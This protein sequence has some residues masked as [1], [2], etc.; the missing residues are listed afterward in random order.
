MLRLYDT[1]EKAIAPKTQIRLYSDTQVQQFD[2]QE[3]K[4]K[5]ELIRQQAEQATAEA[6]RAGSFGGIIKETFKPKNL[7]EAAK[8]VAGGIYNVGKGIVEQYTKPSETIKQTEEMLGYGTTGNKVEDIITTPI[9]TVGK[10]FVRTFG[11]M[12]EP[13]GKDIAEIIF[14][15]EIMP[16]VE[17]GEMPVEV[18]DQLD[19][20]KKSNLQIVGDVSLA[21]LSAYSPTLFTKLT[22]GKVVG[23]QV[24]KNIFQKELV[25]GITGKIAGKGIAS[26]ML[27]GAVQTIPLGTAFGGAQVLASGS[28]DPGE[29]TKIM[30]TN[31]G[32]MGILGA[33]ISGAVPVTKSIL[34]KTIE[35]KAKIQKSLIEKGYPPKEAEIIANH[36]GSETATQK[37]KVVDAKEIIEV[38]KL[39][40][41]KEIKMLEQPKKGSP[42]TGEGFVM[43][44]K[45]DKQ[46]LQIAKAQNEYREAVKIYNEKPTPSTQK[47]ALSAKENYE[48]MTI[49]LRTENVQVREKITTE[50]PGKEAT[51]DK[52]ILRMVMD[53]EGM[54]YAGK[55]GEK[56]VPP[57]QKGK[58]SGVAEKLETK[59]E[60][61]VFARMKAEHPE[62]K[63]DLPYN[64]IKLK[65][66]AKKAVE[67]IA[68]DKE[69]AYRVAM[70]IEQSPDVT[71]TAV[72]IAMS[73]KALADGNNLLY[74]KLVKNR[75]LE[76]TRRGQELVAEKGSV[77]DNSTAR[78]VKE[79]ISVKLEKLGKQYFGDVKNYFKKESNK[80]KAIERIDKEVAK[81]K[82]K[83]SVKRFDIR[84]AQLIID[85]LACK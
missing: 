57:V 55:K 76:Q 1:T 8:T 29:I 49:P 74:S 75:S 71:S 2:E 50:V 15:N 39:S 23:G 17:S 25:S 53:E 80:T 18:L 77:T 48:K 61:R 73:E 26:T 67:L 37:V 28:K 34:N 70:G 52:E 43:T 9:R 85:Q 58:P 51:L 65:E 79:L 83:I 40:A 20:L 14:M 32:T 19:V 82:E 56:V 66:D 6:K 27:K 47:K 64:E 38:G 60:S 72:N 31:I 78:Y 21:V 36:A 12:L 45:A 13:L 42:V 63:G 24:V 10:A 62:L 11:P 68:K 16:K 7:W 3:K 81:A 35:A 46:K 33:I 22:A 5:N 41:P 4:Q 69:K 59:I 30:A 54:P 44:E 84:E